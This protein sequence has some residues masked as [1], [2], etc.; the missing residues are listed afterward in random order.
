MKTK[1]GLHCEVVS[2]PQLKVS[3]PSLGLILPSEGNALY[4]VKWCPNLMEMLLFSDGRIKYIALD[5]FQS[6]C[7]SQIFW[8]SDRAG[9]LARDGHN[10]QVRI[11][12]IVHYCR[13]RI[14]FW[15]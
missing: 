9:K 15:I 3:F 2:D 11:V 10:Y 4:C 14:L 12:L 7:L 1:I 6:F 13:D 8:H 5:D